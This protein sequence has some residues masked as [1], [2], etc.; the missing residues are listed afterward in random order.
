MNLEKIIENSVTK[1]KAR[2]LLIFS[3]FAWSMVAASV[4]ILSFTLGSIMQEWNLTK[5]FTSTLASSTF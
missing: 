4:L 5:T 1:S 3:S 2:T